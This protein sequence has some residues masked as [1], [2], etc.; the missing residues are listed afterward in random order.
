MPSGGARNRSGPQP[1]PNSG[2]SETR[3]LSFTALPSG[4]CDL[5]PPAWPMSLARDEQQAEL[6]VERWAQ[7]WKSPQAFVWHAERWRW[8]AVAHY[9]RMAVVVECGGTASEVTAMIRLA[10]QVGLTPAGLKENGWQ[11]ATDK[12]AER[13]AEKAEP[14][15]EPDLRDRF[16]VVPDGTGG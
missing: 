15:A 14:D 3:G 8:L 12:L 6:E 5:D 1:D 10:D 2:R 11:I 9:V 16:T 4:G 13:R 7:I